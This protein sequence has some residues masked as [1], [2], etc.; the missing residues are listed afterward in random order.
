MSRGPL[1]ESCARLEL[2]SYFTFLANEYE[3]F[4]W[5]FDERTVTVESLTVFIAVS[6]SLVT[7]NFWNV[8]SFEIFFFAFNWI[9]LD[10]T[11]EPIIISRVSLAFKNNLKAVP[12]YRAS[13]GLLLTEGRT[14][15]WALLICS[16][17]CL[18][19]RL[20]PN[21][22]NVISTSGY[23]PS[24]KITFIVKREIYWFMVMPHAMIA[25][26]WYAFPL[27]TFLVSCRVQGHQWNWKSHN[28]LND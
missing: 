13:Y 23:S 26:L 5:I 27:W 14:P 12:R 8:S 19:C 7:E 25:S 15:A 22:Q 2:P 9:F 1:A 6:S 20:E 4:W 28:F 16:P 17:F 11:A 18:E 21:K 10:E 24:M 3:M